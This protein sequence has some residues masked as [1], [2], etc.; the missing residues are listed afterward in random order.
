M[1][2]NAVGKTRAFRI[3]IQND[4]KLTRT[5]FSYS[6]HN[7]NLNQMNS[8]ECG[9]AV[10]HFNPN[11]EPSIKPLKEIQPKSLILSSRTEISHD[12]TVKLARKSAIAGVTNLLAKFNQICQ[13]DNCGVVNQNHK[14]VLTK[15][16]FPQTFE[17]LNMNSTVRLPCGSR[18]FA[19]KKG[20]RKYNPNENSYHVD[21]QI[22][23]D[24]I[25]DTRL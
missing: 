21:T 19:P 7:Q 25:S 20:G 10:I 16:S 11:K 17:N 15:C 3:S 24:A 4:A 8:A 14:S 22:T 5:R 13:N 1:L 9:F 12:E 2:E 6:L 18:T 23:D